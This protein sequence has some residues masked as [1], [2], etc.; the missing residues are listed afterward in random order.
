M[1]FQG[2]GGA[3]GPPRSE[4]QSPSRLERI[5]IALQT[6]EQINV[7]GGFRFNMRD[8]EEQIVREQHIVH[9]VP[10]LR[11]IKTAGPHQ[12]GRAV[13]ELNQAAVALARRLTTELPDVPKPQI[14]NAGG[15]RSARKGLRV[16]TL[17]FTEEP[18]LPNRPPPGKL[19]ELLPPQLIIAVFPSMELAKA[20][21]FT[22]A[23]QKRVV[24]TIPPSSLFY[25]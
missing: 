10:K 9:I 1:T 15:E 3:E 7:V 13:W 24:D 6:N 16:A 12:I 11:D 14:T 2:R 22:V 19:F 5:A 8:G 21:F 17:T 20:A 23:D 18:D 25:Q 4:T